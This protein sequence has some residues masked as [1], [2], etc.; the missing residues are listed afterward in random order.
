MVDGDPAITIGP[1]QSVDIELP[2]GRYHFTAAID[3]ARS[4]PIEIDV[5]TGG[6][7]RLE[8]GTNAAGWRWL[9]VT[10]YATVWCDRYLYLRRA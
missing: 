7:H 10:L 6:D 4:N 9:L 2:S 1:G 3:W 5:S 8:V